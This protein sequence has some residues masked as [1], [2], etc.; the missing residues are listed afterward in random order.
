MMGAVLP[1]QKQGVVD[2][3]GIFWKQQDHKSMEGGAG[4]QWPEMETGNGCKWL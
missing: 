1:V 2:L 3:D 4:K